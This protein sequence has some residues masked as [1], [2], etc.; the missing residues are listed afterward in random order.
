MVITGTMNTVLY[1][2]QNTT[3]INGVR[4]NHPYM[5]VIEN[6][7]NIIKIFMKK[8]FAMFVGEAL[9]IFLYFYKVHFH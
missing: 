4:F 6:N 8:A 2:Y 7:K 1:K 9:C 5:Q 3:D